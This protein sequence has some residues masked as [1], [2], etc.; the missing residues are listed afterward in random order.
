MAGSAAGEKV[1]MLCGEDVTGK[2]RTKDAQGRYACKACLDARSK[3]R[4]TVGPARPVAVAAPRA[5]SE[6]ALLSNLIDQATANQ[7]PPCDSCGVIM[8]KGAV[9]CTRCGHNRQTGK[10][11]ATRVVKA[12]KEPKAAK[13]RSAGGGLLNGSLMDITESFMPMFLAAFVP[14]A[15][16]AAL[17]L[18]EPS[19]G[20]PLMLAALVIGGFWSYIALVIGAFRDSHTGWG[21]ALIVL[22]I[23]GMGWGLILWYLIMVCERSGAKGAYFGSFVGALIAMFVLFNVD[24]DRL[25][26]IMGDNEKTVMPARAEPEAE[27]PTTSSDPG[28]VAPPPVQ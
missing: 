21:I 13:S 18:S 12:P 25:D 6:D 26:D 27:P 4:P 17:A 16:S 5:T 14:V 1:C 7:G 11:T 8:D 28:L 23:L 2:P 10:T 20:V 19:L 9:I 22:A 24:K 3:P 15:V